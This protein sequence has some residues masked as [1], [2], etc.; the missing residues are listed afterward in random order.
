VATH[1]FASG[2]WY[3]TFRPNCDRTIRPAFAISTA[4]MM[5]RVVWHPAMSDDNSRVVIGP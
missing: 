5:I 1:G 2:I 3:T 4:A